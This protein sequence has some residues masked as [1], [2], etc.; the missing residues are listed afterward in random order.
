MIKKPSNLSSYVATCGLLLV[1]SVLLAVLAHNSFRMSS[2]IRTQNATIAQRDADLRV[3][4]DQLY[5]LQWKNSAEIEDTN[6]QQIMAMSVL[7]WQLD[8][9]RNQGGK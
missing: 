3:V 8:K 2:V 1:V 7:Q 9:C 6:N 4:R 5:E